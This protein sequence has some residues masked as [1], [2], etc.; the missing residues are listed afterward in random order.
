VISSS[1][2]PLPDNTRHSQQTDNH[3]LGGIRTHNF[4]SRAAADLRLR[5]RGHWDRQHELLRSYNAGNWVKLYKIMTVETSWNVMAHAQKPD[6]VFRRNGWVHFNRRG[7][8]SSRLLAAELCAS[9]SIVGSNAGYT[10]FRGSVKGT[11]YPPHSPVSPSLPLSY[12]TVCHHISTGVYLHL[13]VSVNVVLRILNRNQNSKA[14]ME[15]NGMLNYVPNSI[16]L[17]TK[18]WNNK[19]Q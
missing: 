6:S 1:Q 12:V 10:M 15:F 8:Q 7:L 9:A 5:R 4:S 17:K 16:K 14:E 2:R 13:C 18:L 11:G 3:T 19:S